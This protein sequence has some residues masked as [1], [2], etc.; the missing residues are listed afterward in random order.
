MSATGACAVCG[1]PGRA[2]SGCREVFYCGKEHQSSDWLARHKAACK[3]FKRS[4]DPKTGKKTL[5]VA[6]RS[7]PAGTVVMRSRPLLIGPTGL[8]IVCLGCLRTLSDLGGSTRKCS[9]CRLPVCSKKCEKE[10][11]HQVE[12]S[13]LKSAGFRADDAYFS[14]IM[15]C[16]MD[17]STLAL[18]VKVLRT[19]VRSDED[20]KKVFALKSR[21]AEALRIFNTGKALRD[22][23]HTILTKMKV[24]R[25]SEGDILRVADAWRMNQSS[26]SCQD[27]RVICGL[28]TGDYNNITNCCTP[29]CASSNDD[30][31]DASAVTVRAKRA[32]AAG[33][34]LTVMR[35]QLTCGTYVRKLDSRQVFFECDCSRCLDPTE[36][37]LYMS[38]ICCRKCRDKGVQSMMVC[39]DTRDEYYLESPWMCEKCNFS[40]DYREYYYSVN[41]TR[42]A[43]HVVE[44]DPDAIKEFISAHMW[45]KGLLHRTHEFIFRANLALRNLEKD[46]LHTLVDVSRDLLE[47]VEKLDPLDLQSIEALRSNLASA[48][49]AG[50]QA[51]LASGKITP[52]KA[53]AISIHELQKLHLQ[54]PNEQVSLPGLHETRDDLANQYGAIPYAASMIKGPCVVCG[55]PGY[56]CPIC[57]SSKALYCTTGHRY[58]DWDRHKSECKILVPTTEVNN[59][60]SQEIGEDGHLKLQFNSVH[61][62]YAGAAKTIPKHDLVM[63]RQP[64]M[65]GPNFWGAASATLCLGCH[66]TVD[67]SSVR[68]CASCGFP[69]CQ[70]KCE[71]GTHHV[72]ECNALKQVGYVLSKENLMG[73]KEESSAY[74]FRISVLRCALVPKMMAGSFPECTP[75]T[76]D[77][78][79]KTEEGKKIQDVISWIQ[80]DLKLPVSSEVILRAGLL[81]QMR[82]VPIVEP[83]VGE[84]A[85]LFPRTEHLLHSCVPN[86][87]SIDIG[88]D[89]DDGSF[90]F[91]V[92]ARREIPAGDPITSPYVSLALG[93]YSRRLVLENFGGCYCSRCLDK[94]ELGLYVGNVCCDQCKGAGEKS[95]KMIS[96]N[97]TDV[98]TADWVC[99][100]CTFKLSKLSLAE[101][102]KDIFDK[103][104]V[105][106]GGDAELYQK[107]IEDNLAPSGVLHPTHEAII[108]AK[109]EIVLKD[110][111]LETRLP[112][113]IATRNISYCDDLLRFYSKVHPSSE[114]LRDFRCVQM[115]YIVT[116]S[117]PDGQV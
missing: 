51:D 80:S 43:L 16:T 95:P 97:T 74:A 111:D 6:T 59:N 85:A 72:A 5:L 4:E 38:S 46:K 68:Q 34:T 15:M 12:C 48:V 88:D 73:W 7:I 67:Y 57:E 115:R 90:C 14:E 79:M 30:P 10:S 70:E 65:I 49:L 89:E 19:L 56:V 75:T 22:A 114:L 92:S 28:H 113:H 32:I 40:M 66:A 69:A 83:V 101:L 47:V 37:G 110:I 52:R 98:L 108:E 20:K 18:A 21:L 87:Y 81:C 25:F 44:H 2:C 105:L 64:C 54:A 63:E 100:R 91:L 102:H 96:V 11:P 109:R 50:V 42:T 3:P 106:K 86:T 112:Q 93:T 35:T 107:F 33:E 77:L 13:L 29:N 82:W 117:L 45:P 41:A 24:K 36:L 1:K 60:E 84:V 26:F 8:E 71:K 17:W 76:P 103:L 55:A 94:T 116:S 27:G 58:R 31:T 62:V 61:G 99:E 53:E 78:Y 9:G 39:T 23:A 104:R